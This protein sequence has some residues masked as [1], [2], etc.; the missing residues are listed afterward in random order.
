MVTS[1]YCKFGY[2]SMCGNMCYNKPR[3]T[4][5]TTLPE[6]FLKDQVTQKTGVMTAKKESALPS[7]DWTTVLSAYRNIFMMLR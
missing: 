7:Q 2:A 6:C 5:C 3:V 1:K 4:L